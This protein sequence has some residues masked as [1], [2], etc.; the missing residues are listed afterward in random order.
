MEQLVRFTTISPA[1]HTLV[2]KLLKKLYIYVIS[3]APRA[4]DN[5]PSDWLIGIGFTQSK[6]DPA[7]CTIIDNHLLY[8]LAVYVDGCL[9]V[10]KLGP[11]IASFKRDFASRFQIVDLGL[12]AWLLGCT[13][14]RDRPRRILRI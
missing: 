7:T 9:P 13:I 10:G 3:E 1:S 11:F 2:C 8:I 6:V 4:W 5:V 14:E 12:A